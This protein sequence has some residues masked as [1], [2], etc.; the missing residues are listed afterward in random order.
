M[1]NVLICE[2]YKSKSISAFGGLLDAH[3]SRP[4]SAHF[5]ISQRSLHEQIAYERSRAEKRSM[6]R[7]LA[8]L[9][10]DFYRG[11]LY[12]RTPERWQS[13]RMR[14]FAKPLYGLTPVPRVRIPPSPPRSLGCRET[15]LR[16][17][18]NRRKSPQFFNSYPQTGLEK[19]P[20]CTPQASFGA[21]FSG[22]HTSSPVSTTPSGEC[23]AITNRRYSE[24]DL[25]FAS[26][27]LWQLTPFLLAN[28]PIRISMNAPIR[29]RRFEANRHVF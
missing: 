9:D 2:R 4:L 3:V 12:S 17:P 20:R 21:V 18:E 8:A 7:E 19:V 15:G 25:T 6:G 5:T 23:N 22:R 14:R 11:K 1:A 10:D 26:T 16:C 29:W 28:C 13:G 27:L 24:S